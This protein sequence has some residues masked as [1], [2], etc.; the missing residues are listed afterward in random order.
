MWPWISDRSSSFWSRRRYCSPSS[1]AVSLPGSSRMP[2][3][4]PR[5]GVG[6]MTAEA[7]A[8]LVAVTVPVVA[9]V[10]VVGLIA[11]IKRLETSRDELT[12]LR[13]RS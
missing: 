10:A 4:S 12:E 5:H 1:V 2:P 13:R 9:L 8:L 11:A 7:V 3:I 6:P